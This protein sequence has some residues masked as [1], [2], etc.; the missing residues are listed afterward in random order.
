M[1]NFR[2][3]STILLAVFWGLLTGA[4]YEFFQHRTDVALSF[5]K[6]RLLGAANSALRE[7]GTASFGSTSL[8][9]YVDM[10][11]KSLGDEE[12]KTWGVRVYVDKPYEL[13]YR[14][15]GESS[16]AIDKGT[17]GIGSEQIGR[18]ILVA[19]DRADENGLIRVRYQ[20][21]VG[22]EYLVTYRD[23]NGDGQWDIEEDW[24]IHQGRKELSSRGLLLDGQYSFVSEL[25]DSSSRQTCTIIERNGRTS[26]V[27]L[28]DG[29]WERLGEAGENRK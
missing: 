17:I 6:M 15:E 8:N 24:T 25:S 12:R 29:K 9:G 28:V 7:D 5:A 1:R 13:G 4:L 21:C 27:S 26:V 10:V 18:E 16:E 11:A 2:K 14:V 22:S 23:L 19:W 20:T 3:T